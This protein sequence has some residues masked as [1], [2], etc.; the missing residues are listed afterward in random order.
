[1]CHSAVKAE[2]SMTFDIIKIIF[3]ERNQGTHFDKRRYA[4]LFSQKPVSFNL[5]HFLNLFLIVISPNTLFFPLYN[6]GT[7]LHI[8]VYIIFS[9]IVV[10]HCKLMDA[11]YCFWN[12]LIMRSCCI[13]LRTMSKSLL[14]LHPYLISIMKFYPN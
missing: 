10:L 4:V 9:P 11:N 1:M 14:K 5:N 13:A 6:M 8:H 3:D 12:G 7:Q 2:C